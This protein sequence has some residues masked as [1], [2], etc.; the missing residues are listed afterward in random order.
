VKVTLVNRFHAIVAPG[1]PSGPI[2]PGERQF[3]TTR[4][5]PAMLQGTGG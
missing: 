1:Q 4:I 3:F 5:T 2:T